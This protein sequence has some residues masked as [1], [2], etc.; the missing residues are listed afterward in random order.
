MIDRSPSC[1]PRG[2]EMRAGHYHEGSQV[3]REPCIKAELMAAE[4]HLA[5]TVPLGPRIKHLE[6]GRLASLRDGE[7]DSYFVTGGGES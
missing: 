7:L 2:E 1:V 6:S 4:T 3:C 5:A